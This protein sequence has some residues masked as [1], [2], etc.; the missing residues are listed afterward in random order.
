[1]YLRT[2]ALLAIALFIAFLTLAVAGV[3]Q[4]QEAPFKASSTYQGS[5]LNLLSAEDINRKTLQ[6]ADA[7]RAA[8]AERFLQHQR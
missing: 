6:A 1:M 2:A 5:D 4:R 7:I 8:E 3:T